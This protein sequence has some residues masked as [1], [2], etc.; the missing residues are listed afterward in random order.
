MKTWCVAAAGIGMVVGFFSLPARRPSP[1]TTLVISGHFNGSLEPCGCTSP[2]IGGIRRLSTLVE[3]DRAA[4]PT[5]FI[6]T[7]NA[8]PAAGGASPI[9]LRQNP[10]KAE[11]IAEFASLTHCDAL[12][13]GDQE[14]SYGPGVLS[15]MAQLSGN[16]A[17]NS[18][19]NPPASVALKK[20]ISAQGCLIACASPLS[21]SDPAPTQLESTT[22]SQLS[23]EASANRQISILMMTSGREAAETLAR[24]NPKLNLII[25][26]SLGSATS[27][28]EKIGNTWL[29][30]PGDL[31]REALQISLRDGQLEAFQSIRLGPEFA[32]AA[33][34]K[35]V[36][37]DYLHRVDQAELLKLWPRTKTGKYAGSAACLS[38]HGS[39]YSVWHGS[40]H[41]RAYRDLLNQGHGQDP[42]C[43]NCHVTGLGSLQGFR[44]VRQ[45]PRLARVSCES[46]HGPGAAHAAN[47]RWVKLSSRQKVCVSCH[48]L[49]NSPN[50]NYETYWLKIKHH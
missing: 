21:P 39:A 29:V 41:S 15:E 42:D 26:Q 4:G 43:V 13:L 22:A 14:A 19:E 20:F 11:A 24:Q 46:C 31:G 1:S 8:V 44:S 30:S 10:M 48:T 3:Q 9:G 5:L 34:G 40:A 33:T 7:P 12:G 47:P 35:A 36:M 28:P 50:F 6:L 27:Q 23:A 37:T 32:S 2:M 17:L 25:Y 45:T 38:C 49:E 16:I 18:T